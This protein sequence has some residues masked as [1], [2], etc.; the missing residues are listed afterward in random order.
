MG[1]IYLRLFIIFL[2]VWKLFYAT[3][4][5]D[6]LAS[7]LLSELIITLNY[8][9]FIVDVAIERKLNTLKLLWVLEMF[10]A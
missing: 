7:N 8:C 4:E 6:V 9:H 2:I 3:M 1:G 5:I 10:W